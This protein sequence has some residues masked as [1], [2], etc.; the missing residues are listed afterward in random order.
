MEKEA[1]LTYLDSPKFITASSNSSRLVAKLKSAV[2]RQELYETHQIL[3]TVYFRF[4]NYKEKVAALLDLLYHGS[5]Y[6]LKFKEFISGQDTALLLLET[7][8][9]CLQNQL[10]LGNQ[11][12]KS[13]LTNSSLTHH[14]MNNTLDIDIS[15]KVANL[16]VELP[17]TDVGQTKFIAEALRILSPKLLN[18]DLFH[19]VVAK[20]YWLNKNYVNARYHYLRCASI[21][22]AQDI[23][24]LLVEYHCESA[25]RSEVDLFITQ[26]IFQLLCLQCPLDPPR[27]PNQSKPNIVTPPNATI[28][29]KL[30]NTIKLIAEKIFS[31]YTLKHPQLS[32]VEIPFSSLPLL[33]F[34]YFIISIIDS[35]QPEGA[36]F[37]VLCDIYKTTWG[38]DPNYQSYLKRIGSIY[39]GVVDQA[40]QQQQ[41]GGF[42][43]NIL[44]SLLEGADDEEEDSNRE[45]NNL[46]S[47]D[48]LD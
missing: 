40:K 5:M 38:R 15:Q 7:A 16:V 13:N 19:N 24:T 29:K 43:N 33:N 10:E 25:S 41:Q 2:Q 39:F 32:Q 34:T 30:R 6:L 48:E 26:F 18:R 20:K 12:A 23:A 31:T 47:C 46:S 27:V 35:N 9:K 4:S 44:M 1:L 21:E 3:R 22:N 11:E 17:D 37:R 28:S 45:G 42:F 36:A 8:A 14:T